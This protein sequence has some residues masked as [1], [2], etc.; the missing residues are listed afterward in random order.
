MSRAVSVLQWTKAEV[1]GEKPQEIPFTRL[2]EGS[3]G[4]FFVFY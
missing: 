1:N 4:R 2:D 3:G